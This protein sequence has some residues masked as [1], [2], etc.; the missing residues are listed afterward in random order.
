M[1]GRKPIY[2]KLLEDKDQRRSHMSKA[3]IERRVKSTTGLTK[4]INANLKVPKHLSPEAKSEWRKLVALY[5]HMDP[6]VITDM[7]VHVL[8]VYCNAV[9][10]YRKAI[11]KLA[12]TSE[13]YTSKQNPGKPRVNPWHTIAENAAITIARFG[14]SLMVDPVSR[15][16]FGLANAKNEEP[17]S[18]TDM[19]FRK[20]AERQLQEARDRDPFDKK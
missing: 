5:R 18:P 13:V 16:R 15:A 7:D 14:Q 12:E 10:R 19:Y 3:D 20:K 17:E 1:P 6:P 4:G 9:V 11:V 8:E 2:P